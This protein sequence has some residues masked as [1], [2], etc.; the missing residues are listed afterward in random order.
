MKISNEELRIMLDST[1]ADWEKRKGAARTD[2]L[3]RITAERERRKREKR[4]EREERQR[5]ESARAIRRA[6]DRLKADA[7]RTHAE[8]WI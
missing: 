8:S 7:A 2:A 5:E 4:N 1:V 3:K 6:I